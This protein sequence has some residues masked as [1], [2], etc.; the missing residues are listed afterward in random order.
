MRRLWAILG[1]VLFLVLAPGCVAGLAPWWISRWHLQPPF[2]G[3]T[4][5][6]VAGAA[7]IALGTPMLLDS[8]ARFALQGLGTPAPVFPT[9]GN[10]PLR[11]TRF[12]ISPQTM[13]DSR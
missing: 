5:F 4:W 10:D 2:L 12:R 8:F 3:L 6:R 7:L 9:Q 13:R 1:S 11:R